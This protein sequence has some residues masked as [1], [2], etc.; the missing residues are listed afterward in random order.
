VPLPFKF[1]EGEVLQPLMYHTFGAPER[2]KNTRP[3]I[4]LIVWID[5]YSQGDVLSF[6]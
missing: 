2:F 3:D 5:Q 6:L 4:S 1:D